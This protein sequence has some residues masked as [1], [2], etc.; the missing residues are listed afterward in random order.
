MKTI[1]RFT[2]TLCA[3][4]IVLVSCK[5]EAVSSENKTAAANNLPETAPAVQTAV[6]TNV[7][8]Q[9]GGFYQALPARYDSTTKKYPLLVVIHGGPTG[10]SR[11]I[12]ATTR[13]AS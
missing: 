12:P 2:V 4:A 9:I 5:K 8:A 10:T 1:L 11:A 13:S 7:N 6:T 3:A